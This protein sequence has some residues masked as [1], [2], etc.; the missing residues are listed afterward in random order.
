MYVCVCNIAFFPARINVV[1]IAHTD[2]LRWKGGR[3]NVRMDRRTD[4][5]TDLE[6]RCN[7]GERVLT[8]IC[9]PT[10]I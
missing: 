1:T 4:G 2:G 6:Y 10:M 8:H 7:I 3:A 9:L 5:L